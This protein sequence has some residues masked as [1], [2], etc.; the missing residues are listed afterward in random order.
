MVATGALPTEQRCKDMNDVQWLWY[1]L[2]LAKDKEEE[3][4]IAKNYM[5]YLGS[6]INPKLAKAVSEQEARKRKQEE[7]RKARQEY[8]KNHPGENISL[9]QEAE[10]ELEEMENYDEFENISYGENIVN[11]DFEKELQ[12]AL[13]EGGDTEEDFVELSS[14]TSAGDASE[15]AEDFFKRV[16]YFSDMAG[17]KKVDTNPFLI[18]KKKQ[19]AERRNHANEFAQEERTNMNYSYKVSSGIKSQNEYAPESIEQ[20][21]YEQLK[22]ERK[23]LL[24]NIQNK[25][26]SENYQPTSQGSM[27]DISSLQTDKHGNVDVNQIFNKND[28]PLNY[29]PE[30]GD[31]AIQTMRELEELGFGADCGDCY[32]DNNYIDCNPDNDFFVDD[33]Y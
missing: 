17:Q 12:Q 30:A 7:R 11:D 32:T 14:S 1:Y 16:Q 6:Y 31:N 20:K 27:A 23:A 29:T 33:D 25:Q 18:A 22:K 5:D 8:L 24:N 26:N 2:N 13:A 19:I 3:R 9:R 15:T 4:D 21:R 28:I 10:N